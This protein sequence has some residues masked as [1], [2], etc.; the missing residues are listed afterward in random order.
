MDGSRSL[1]TSPQ[2]GENG[3]ERATQE[4]GELSV[5]Q[6]GVVLFF[7]AGSVLFGQYGRRGT[8]PSGD[9]RGVGLPAPVPNARQNKSSEEPLA[10]F[11]GVLREVSRK[12][13]TIENA[14]SNHIEF[15]CSKKTTFYD[16]AKKIKPSALKNGDPISVEARSGLDGS[17]EAVNI[18]LSRQKHEQP[19]VK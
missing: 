12:V 1:R 19:A 8:Y 16:G 6:I 2:T 4:I 17:L 13:F 14:D 9:T 10:T 15:R 11:T 7:V 3:I 18:H 5:K